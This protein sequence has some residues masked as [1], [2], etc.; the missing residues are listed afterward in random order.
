LQQLENTRA[1]R[2]F[3]NSPDGAQS[4]SNEERNKE[5]EEIKKYEIDIVRWLREAKVEIANQ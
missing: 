5:L 4:M 1:Y 3:L 2:K